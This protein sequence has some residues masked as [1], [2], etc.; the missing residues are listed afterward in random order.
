ME[1]AREFSWAKTAEKI[2]RGF[3]T[4]SAASQKN[5]GAQR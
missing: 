1:R 5:E 2:V 3:D 4:I